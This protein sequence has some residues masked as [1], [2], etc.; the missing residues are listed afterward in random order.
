[1]KK[2][3]TYIV[4]DINKA[5]AFEWIASY[6]D[7]TKFNIDFILINDGISDLE[8]YLIE[9]QIPVLRVQ[10]KRKIDGLLAIYKVYR[11]LKKRKTQI[12]H[13]HLFIANLVGLT[14]AFIAG[15]K[16]R[17]HTR[18]HSDFHHV[19]FPKAVKYD[20]YV[21]FMSTDIVAIT[22]IVKQILI[23]LENVPEKKIH[24]IHHG[25]QL[26][27][28]Y[29]VPLKSIE[30]LK[31][32]YQ[33][34]N[35]FPIVGAISRY[36]EW[37]GVQYLIPAYKLLL[38]KYPDALLVLANAYGDCKHE[39]KNLLKDIP[40]QNYI[41]IQFENDLFALYKLFDVFVHIPI[42]KRAEAFGQ[43]YVEAL[44]S[45]I[46]SVFT[47]AGVADEFIVHRHNALVV[48]YENSLAVY[49]ELLELLTNQHLSNQLVINGK[50]DVNEKFQL[51]KMILALEDLYLKSE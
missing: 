43:I 16:K 28:F 25:F 13:T 47:N 12:V 20:R 14:A 45:G 18:H 29:N 46:P 36:T 40:K 7:K 19:K 51:Q 35:Q 39:I 50:I 31:V 17:I 5:L 8:K 6:I 10:Y 9:N 41:E 32:K 30:T 26:E 37:K 42:N 49:N 11:I 1:M 24:L 38:E 22:E 4:S 27:N 48:P 3:L 21:N 44:A 34:S 15:V 33:I 23:S 2:N